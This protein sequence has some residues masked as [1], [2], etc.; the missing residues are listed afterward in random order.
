[1]QVTTPDDL[2]DV[3][4]SV[5]MP[6]GLEPLDPRLQAPSEMRTTST[7]PVPPPSRCEA[8]WWYADAAGS[9]STGG[10]GGFADWA[11]PAGPY[12]SQVALGLVSSLP[13]VATC[14][15]QSTSDRSVVF[16]VPQLQAGAHSFAVLAVAATPGTP[17]C[18]LF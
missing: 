17:L 12:D 7:L 5:L 14:A 15:V 18:G 16:S 9:S 4:V 11:P 8:P 13:W 1:M 3:T 6:G 2:G 10:N